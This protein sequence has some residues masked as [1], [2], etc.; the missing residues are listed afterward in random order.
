MGAASTEAKLAET[1]KCLDVGV[2]EI[3]MVINI[4]YLKAGL[5]KSV[6][7]EI[8]TLKE[9]MGDRILKVIIETCYLSKEEIKMACTIAAKAGADFV[10]TSTGFGPGGATM[11]DV[12]LIFETVGPEVNVKAS[13]GIKTGR[14]ALAYIGLGAQRIGTSNG[15][16]I[17]KTQ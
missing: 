12:A 8:T 14:D 15:I 17:I 6:R 13:G 9:A 11:K 7:E 16:K 4:G 1:Q 2:D 10:K 3:D 5:S